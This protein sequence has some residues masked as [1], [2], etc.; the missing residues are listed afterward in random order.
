[1]LEYEVEEE[2]ERAAGHIAAAAVDAEEPPGLL[3][4]GAGEDNDSDDEG[5]PNQPTP[6]CT[7]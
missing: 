3:V 1:M 7:L 6:T 2:A 4:G 5:E